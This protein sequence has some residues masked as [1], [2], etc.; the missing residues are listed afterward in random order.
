MEFRPIVEGFIGVINEVQ[1]YLRI[2]IMLR[3]FLTPSIAALNKIKEIIK[4]AVYQL[5]D[6]QKVK[7]NKEILNHY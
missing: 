6:I 1:I 2:N 5:I 4:N 7:R 3:N